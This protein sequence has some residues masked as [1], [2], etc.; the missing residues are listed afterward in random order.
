MERRAAGKRRR[1]GVAILAAVAVLGTAGWAAGA[2]Q[3]VTAP[4]PGSS[5][6]RADTADGRHP[7]SPGAEPADVAT[8][9][10]GL[11]DAGARLARRHPLVAGNLDGAPPRLR[12]RANRLA[13]RAERAR[14]HA[15]AKDTG[16]TPAERARARARAAHYGRLGTAG[17]QILAFDPRGRGQVAEVL[18]DLGTADRVAVLV[19]GADTDLARLEGKGADRYGRPLGA[20]EALRAE[21]RH[22]APRVRTAVV[23]WVGY[24]APSGL[25]PDAAT[26]RLA[27]AGAPRLKRFL[28]GLAAAGAPADAVFCHSY[29][30]VVCGLAA[31]GTDAFRDLVVYGSPGVR[32]DSAG[33]LGSARVWAA[34]SGGDWIGRVPH[35][36][37]GGLGHGADPADR[38]FG[39]RVV[40]TSGAE[41]HAGY[42]VP[43]TASL[44]NF[45]SIA[46][47]RYA[48]V[49][50]E[51]GCR[52]G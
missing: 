23:A 39:A 9:F 3:P 47:G 38:G 28:R 21:M 1:R 51:S 34:R 41:G 5:A 52:R 18:G 24:T 25:G 46:L 45:A 49:T 14:Q 43:G 6:W 31:H 15:R 4:P 2:E 29:G 10:A 50:C 20:A 40:D 35:V 7:P 44:R 13:L 36:D 33:E 16:R 27:E 22:A 32:A 37:I 11:R 8:Y 30:S 19:P 48:D 17:R 42:L 12:Y 26:G